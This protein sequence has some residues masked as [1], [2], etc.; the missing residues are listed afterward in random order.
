MY[1]MKKFTCNICTEAYRK[2]S[3]IHQHNKIH[4]QNNEFIKQYIIFSFDELDI[5]Y[6]NG[7]P[8]VVYICWFGCEKNNLPTMSINRFNAFKSLVSHINIPIILLTYI[9]YNYFVKAEYPLHDGFQYLSGVHKADYFRCYML[10]HYG[11]GYHDIK[12]RDIGWE[13]EWNTNNWTSNRNIWMYGRREKYSGA[14]GYPPGKKNIQK[15]FND[16]VTMGWIICRP[17]TKYTLMLLAHIELVLDKHNDALKKFPAKI[18]S[19]YYSDKPYALVPAN[20]YP[21]RW[22]EILGEIYHPLMLTYKNHIK[23]GLSDARK[24]RYK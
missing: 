10:H 9:N 2:Y 3:T 12:Q 11:G 7:I 21:I 19:G 15:Y 24:G 5:E 17:N 23:Y 8:K 16:L 20:A 14:I 4:T 1:S 13:N 18:P 22:L 6:I